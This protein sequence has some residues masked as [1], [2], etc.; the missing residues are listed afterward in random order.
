MEAK[1]VMIIIPGRKPD[2]MIINNQKKKKKKKENLLYSGYC[3]TNGPQSE[4]SKQAKRE[5]NT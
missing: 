2:L 1:L 4:K 5:I 3:C